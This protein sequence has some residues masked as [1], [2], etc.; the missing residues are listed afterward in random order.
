MGLHG[1]TALVGVAGDNEMGTS[2]GAFYGFRGYGGIDCNGNGTDDVCEI[3]SGDAS[4]LN[5]NDVPDECDVLGDLDGDGVVGI[6]DFLDLLAVW[7]PCP[8][9]CPPHCLGDVDTDCD[10]G[11]TDFLILL[12]NWS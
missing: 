2:A 1:A 9:P 8:E 5:G 6:T 11:V 12:A 4:D 3:I 7:G 10:V